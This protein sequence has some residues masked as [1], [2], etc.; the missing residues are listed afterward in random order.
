MVLVHFCKNDTL[1]I[2]I[3]G[4]ARKNKMDWNWKHYFHQ[5]KEQYNMYSATGITNNANHLMGR[6]CGTSSYEMQWLCQKPV[7]S[8][9]K[10][11]AKYPSVQCTTRGNYACVLFCFLFH[12][13]PCVGNPACCPHWP[14]S[15][16]LLTLYGLWFCQGATQ[17]CRFDW[18]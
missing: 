1:H 2:Q 6:K 8:G 9:S 17:P 4:H 15:S 16:F 5:N 11:E 13:L 14:F 18:W 3:F 12:R 7:N 10:N